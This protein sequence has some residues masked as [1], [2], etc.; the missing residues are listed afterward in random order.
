MRRADGHGSADTGVLP[1]NELIAEL[2]PGPQAMV[3]P[4]T[5]TGGL[6]G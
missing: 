2:T 5:V 6:G 4:V 1:D 3:K